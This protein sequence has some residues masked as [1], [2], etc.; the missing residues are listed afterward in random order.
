MVNKDFY[1][2]CSKAWSLPIL[3]YLQH[4]HDPRISP[5]S[6][7]LTAGR[8]ALSASIQHLIELGYVLRNPG[9]GHPL[10]PAYLL[11]DK[12]VRVAQWAQKLDS[13]LIPPDW[14]LVRKTWTLPVLRLVEPARRYG[15]F[16]SLLNPITDRA[17]SET[18]K[19]LNRH[20]WIK[21]TVNSTADKPLI[22]KYLAS[23]EGGKIVECL[24]QSFSID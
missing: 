8:T 7:H 17:L 14:E 2:L 20:N 23:K 15:E 21:R 16:R 6:H 13:L 12:G 10:R 22:V 3:I 11:S 24:Q 9:H 18:L 5:M 4:N 19:R 1:L